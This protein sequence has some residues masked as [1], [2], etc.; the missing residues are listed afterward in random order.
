MRV[1]ETCP[2]PSGEVVLS[3]LG[4]EEIS[5]ACSLCM[6]AVLRLSRPCKGS[7]QDLEASQNLQRVTKVI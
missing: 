4:H 7:A 5:R 1:P 2:G 3:F 6:R